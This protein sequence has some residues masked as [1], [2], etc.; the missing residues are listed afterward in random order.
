MKI[1]LKR[2]HPYIRG[3]Y[4]YF[5]IAFLATLLTAACTAWG[6]YLVKPVLDDI[7][8]KKNTQMLTLLPFLV[9]LAY[10]GK[11]FGMYVQMYFMNYIGLDI[12]RKIRDRMLEHLLKME[13]GFFNKIRSGE[14]ISRITNDIG[15]IRAS[16]SNFLAEFVRESLTVIGLVG[17]VI[18]QSPKLAIVGLVI[19]P[20]A[21]YPLASIIKKIKKISRLNQ[22][23]NSDITAKLSEIFNNVE[24][25]KASNGEKIEQKTFTEE[26][27]KFFK[28]GLKATLIGQ[29]SSPLMEFLGS[30]A[31]ALVIYLGGTEVIAGKMSAGAFFSFITALFML[32]TPF[33][34]LVN[35]ASSFQEAFV[36]TD[37]IFEI[38][39]RTPQIQDGKKSLCPPIQKI[40]FKDVYLKYDENYVLNNINA[41]FSKNQ[42]IALVGKSGSGKSSLVNL[43]LRLYEPNSGKILIN[44]ELIQSY[45]QESIRDN[46]AIVTQ[47][48]FIFNDTIS[49]NV[50]YGA[51]Y[52]KQKII[53]SLKKAQ[54]WSFVSE[55]PDGI[56]TVLDE[57]GVN[58]SGGQRQRIAIARAI[59]KDPEVLILDEATSALDAKTE[60]AFKNTINSIAKDKIIILIAHR[61]STIEL[62]H[63]IYRFEDG[64]IIEESKK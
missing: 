40:D 41:E 64:R 54:A 12:V 8:I 62:A 17:V 23:K 55:L 4:V 34:R 30:I 47:R 29:L 51:K 16:V 42:I 13:M 28:L 37:R 15:L 10:F 43:I 1:F 25:I 22:E 35:I 57:F 39:D 19:M 14:L 50:A 31:I 7:F 38:L 3:Y 46:I 56:D 45:K 18:Y 6:T 49:A 27:Q 63:K 11:S 21:I 9:V 59:Y 61:P 44:G 2:F 32:Y 48:I 36:A 26:N 53:Q 33:K 5:F 52:D 58:L 24:I 60:E 20:L